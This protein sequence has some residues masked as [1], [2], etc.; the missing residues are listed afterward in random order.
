MRK[1]KKIFIGLILGL[2]CAILPF[3]GV[4][5]VRA[6]DTIQINTEYTAPINLYF[7]IFQS[8]NLE[9]K[10]P[11]YNDGDEIVLGQL[12]I[13]LE[14]YTET[15]KIVIKRNLIYLLFGL[16][17]DD[18]FIPLYSESLTNDDY[19]WYNED[20]SLFD[21]DNGYIYISENIN[22]FEMYENVTFISFE[23]F[24]KV[25]PKISIFNTIISK[26]TNY[27]TGLFSAVGLTFSSAISIFY[28]NSQL[29][30]LGEIIAW[31][32]GIGL[33]AAA[34]YVVYRL[35]KNSASKLASGIKVNKDD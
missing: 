22:K 18:D 30:F 12:T 1:Y 4:A 20:E 16:S 8:I 23:P 10:Y 27:L 9:E 19:E 6:D 35:I 21:I 7:D 5:E 31:G 2:M 28:N 32:V 33:V 11:I 13:E 26:I 3:V 24:P 25:F 17:T 34:I 29:T 14:D 15:F